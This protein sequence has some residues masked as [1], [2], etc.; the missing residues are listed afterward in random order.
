MI[1]TVTLL[2]ASILLFG[3]RWP[4][5][6]PLSVESPDGKLSITF[7]LKTQS[8]PYL[9]GERAYYRVSYQGAP[10]LSDSPLGLDFYEAPVLNHDF[11]VV[12]TDRRSHNETWETVVGAQKKIPDNYNELTIALRE[13][14]SPGRRVDLIFRAY[15][16][17]VAFRYFLPQ[18]AGMEKFALAAENTGFYFARD[19][20]A[21]ALNMG[22]MNTN[23]EGEYLRVRLN[24][25]KPSSIINLPLLFEIPGGPWVALLEA[26]LTDYAGMYVSGVPGFD[27]ALVSALSR[28]P[29]RV[30]SGW[31]LTWREYMW[32]DHPV[33]GTTPK[34]TPWRVLMVAPSPGRLIETNYLNMNLSPPCALTDTSWIKPGKT[35]LF[36]WV[37]QYPYPVKF[38]AG[39][40]METLRHFIDFSSKYRFE[41][42]LIDDGWSTHEDVTRALPGISIPDLVEY[43]R[44]KGVKILLWAPWKPVDKQ[45]DEAFA[46]YEKWGVSGVK[47]DFMDRD[48]Q[49]MVNF[50]DRVVKKAAQHHLL[51]DFHGAFKPTGLRRRYPNLITREAVMG[52]E[53][54]LWS[55]WATPQHDVTIPF[56]RMIAGPM[57]YAPGAFRNA[58]RSAFKPGRIE[59]VSQ[60]TRAHQL[61]LYVVFESPLQMVWGYP[62]AY[63]NQPGMEFLE[64]VPTT[65]DETRVLKGEI[66]QYI[67]LARR[68]GSAWYVGALTD[69][70]ERDMTIPLDFLGAGDYDAQLFADGPGA[71]SDATDL[72]I[73]TT[74][75]S[76][77]EDLKIHLASGGGLA[78]ILAPVHNPGSR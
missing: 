39:E 70:N 29:R 1:R 56:T 9:P 72:K 36:W 18:Q 49:W 46:L 66:G 35:S 26:D 50:Y 65:W 25:I 27:N 67:A 64:K 3:A 63:E 76:A 32:K 51:V 68:Y 58:T 28:P 78:A 4:A 31:N 21:Y 8:Q 71:N 42:A 33:T 16:E 24:E 53:Y 40:N 41:Y 59:S 54:S 30:D 37:G 20:S 48:D 69:W 15:N 11:Q 14:V 5:A 60:G 34:A 2:L 74:R 38:Q 23:N 57:D 13:R 6:E 17:G 75:V 61:A 10:L 22:R 12:S 52:I 62:E 73:T 7:E 77:G 43:G 44:K 55:N 45:M 19:A 47:V